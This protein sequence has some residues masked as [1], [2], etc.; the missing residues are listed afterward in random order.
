MLKYVEESEAL[1]VSTR[2]LKEQVLSRDESSIKVRIAR[3]ARCE[4]NKKLFH[5][6]RQGANAVFSARKGEM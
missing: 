3:Q 6:F 1:T 2:E 5:I 4:K